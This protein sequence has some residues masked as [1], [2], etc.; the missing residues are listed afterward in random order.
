MAVP[1]VIEPKDRKKRNLTFLDMFSLSK[2]TSLTILLF[3]LSSQSHRSISASF[4][5]HVLFLFCVFEFPRFV[6]QVLL[7]GGGT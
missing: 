4:F 3:F 5:I 7:V 2:H 6:F 1:G